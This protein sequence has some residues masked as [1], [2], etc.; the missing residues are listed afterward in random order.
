MWENSEA[1]E[2]CSFPSACYNSGMTENNVQK[3]EKMYN[4]E[5]RRSFQRQVAWQIYFPLFLFLLVI[6]GVAVGFS[7]GG[8]G[9]ASLWADISVM[10]LSIPIL[11]IGIVLLV[12][13]AGLAY[14][15][16]WVI[17]ALP[18]PA[19]QA[20]TIISEITDRI[21]SIA[22]VSAEPFIRLASFTAI[23]RPGKRNRPVD[24]VQGEKQE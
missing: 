16:N 24:V 10:L 7:I 8:G 14:G 15:V 12:L 21:I 9:S 13:A 4:E 20:Q 23:F 18:Q 17:K 3:D 2:Y 19:H 6:V 22:D 5:T 1:L 11:I